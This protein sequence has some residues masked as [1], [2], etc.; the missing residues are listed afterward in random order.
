ML[1]SSEC[2]NIGGGSARKAIEMF[3]KSAEKMEE[4]LRT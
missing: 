2:R 3:N 4:K 1:K